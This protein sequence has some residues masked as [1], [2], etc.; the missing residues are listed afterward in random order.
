M[1]GRSKFDFY[2]SKQVL[3]I[4]Q[5]NRDINNGAIFKINIIIISVVG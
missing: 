4:S 5:N 3:T 1:F 2:S